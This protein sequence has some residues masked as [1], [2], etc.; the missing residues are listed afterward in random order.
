MIFSRKNRLFEFLICESSE[1][2]KIFFISSRRRTIETSNHF[3]LE[4]D[5]LFQMN[6]PEFCIKSVKRRRPL[7]RRSPLWHVFHTSLKVFV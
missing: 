7:G 4:L 1:Y 3:Q 5:G 2:K 6:F